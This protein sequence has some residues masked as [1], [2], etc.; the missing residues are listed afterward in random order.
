MAEQAEKETKEN[1]ALCAELWQKAAGAA[2]GGAEGRMG[3]H[4]GPQDVRS[5]PLRCGAEP[6][7]L[8]DDPLSVV[9]LWEAYTPPPFKTKPTKPPE[10]E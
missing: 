4:R 2:A 8:V 7:T 1:G 5:S 10:K 9:R 6:W 3:A